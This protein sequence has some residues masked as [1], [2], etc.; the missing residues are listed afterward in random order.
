MQNQPSRGMRFIST[1]VANILALLLGAW[2]LPGIHVEG[3]D[4]SIILIA[5]VIAL[6]N[7]FVRP[8]LILLTIPATILT[9]G[10]FILVINAT[11][12]MLAGYLLDDF[13]VDGFWSAFFFAL[14]LSV[15]TSIIG[16]LD[17]GPQKRQ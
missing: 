6:L 3:N 9:L 12:I 17:R 5:F 10:L 13:I 14:I 2:I 4:L 1:L 11:V 16:K 8:L 15:V 7:A